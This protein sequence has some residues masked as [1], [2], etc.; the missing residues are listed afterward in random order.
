MEH[1][2]LGN[3]P[4]CS[5]RWQRITFSLLRLEPGEHNMNRDHLPDLVE[6]EQN[7][8][9]TYGPLLVKEHVRLES[10]AAP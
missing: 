6:M 3:W 5:E 9:F 8:V 4:L 1:P 2:I 7:N 10:K